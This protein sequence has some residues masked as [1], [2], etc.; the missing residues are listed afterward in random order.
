MQCTR[1]KPPRETGDEVPSIEMAVRGTEAVEEPGGGPAHGLEEKLGRLQAGGQPKGT[2]RRRREASPAGPVSDARRVERWKYACVILSR[3]AAVERYGIGGKPGPCP[4]SGSPPG[5]DGRL[6]HAGRR[7]ARAGEGHG[8]G[9]AWWPF[10]R[11]VVIEIPVTTVEGTVRR[12]PG[13][14][15]R[16]AR[17]GRGGAGATPASQTEDPVPSCRPLACWACRL[18]EAWRPS[19]A[20]R[21]AD[22]RRRP[23]GAH[24]LG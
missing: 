18:G 13:D 24:R 4:G 6:V 16:R 14:G 17:Q 2:A 10:A 3:H 15:A 1:E 9:S 7:R 11:N 21:S 8:P 19:H 5:G 20:C 23:V 12:R 22:R